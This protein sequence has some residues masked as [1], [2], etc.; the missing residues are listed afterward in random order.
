MK[1][2]NVCVQINI[3]FKLNNLTK[4]LFK[5][6]GLLKKIRFELYVRIL[7]KY[8][9]KHDAIVL[10]YLG[11]HWLHWVTCFY[12]RNKNVRFFSVKGLLLESIGWI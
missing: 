4:I 8:F 10:K 3:I 12:L 7:C 2:L 1:S 9:Y 11:L 5:T 6:F